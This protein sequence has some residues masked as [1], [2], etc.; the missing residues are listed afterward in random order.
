MPYFFD[1][2]DYDRISNIELKKEIDEYGEVIWK[3][4][5]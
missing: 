4:M 1:V 3:Q 2:V 5:K